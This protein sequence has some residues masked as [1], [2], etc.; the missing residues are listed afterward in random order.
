MTGDAAAA[1]RVEGV[2]KTFP[3]GRAL[4]NATLEVRAGEVHGLVGGNGSGKSTLIKI[5]AGVYTADPGQ[6]TVQMGDSEPVGV[7]NLSPEWARDAGLHFVHQ[8]PAVFPILD[9]MSNIAIGRGFPTTG[10]WW[11]RTRFLRKRTQAILDRYGINARPDDMVENLSAAQRTMVAIARALQDQDE[12]SGGLLVLDEPTA[13]LPA[14]EV[15]RLLEAL[16]IFAHSGQSIIFVSH[17][18]PEVLG[19]S[20]RV[21]VLRDGKVVSTVD[22]EGLTEERLVELILGRKLETLERDHTLSSGAEGAVLH[23]RGLTGGPLNGATLDVRQ[24]EVLG[25]AGLVG[26]GRTEL[27]KSIFGAYRYERG[28]ILLDGQPIRFSHIDEAMEAGFAYVP[29]DRGTEGGFL[30]MTVRSNLSA[31]SL[32]K[33]WRGMKLRHGAEHRDAEELIKIYDI[34]TQNDQQ[35]FST[36]SGGNQQKAIIARWLRRQPRILLLDEP[37]HGVDAG[38]RAQIYALIEEASRNGTSVIL[39]S[40]DYDELALLADRVLIMTQGQ[41]TRE[42]AGEMDADTIGELVLQPTKAAGS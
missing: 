42:I 3:G 22:S 34:R 17:R 41:I 30:D 20:D 8:D 15:D 18:T 13:S 35:V 38:A 4:D 10:P 21:T 29:E 25:I 11:I 33:Y 12:H 19:F 23:V 2:T 28:T 37:T 9:V 14:P 6:G 5:L 16:R 1:L 32:N 31:G 39:V 26:S 27:L 36:L 40:S 24:G 7:D